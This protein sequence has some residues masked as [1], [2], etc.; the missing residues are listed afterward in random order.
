[1][2]FT[3]LASILACI[4]AIKSMN[5]PTLPSECPCPLLRQIQALAP[6]PTPTEAHIPTIKVKPVRKES[7]PPQKLGL[8]EI[9]KKLEEP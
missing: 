7:K 9:A 4:I 2:I 1:M 8:L 3:A 5:A 6:A